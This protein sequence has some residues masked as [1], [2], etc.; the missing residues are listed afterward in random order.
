MTSRDAN[1]VARVRG[2]QERLLGHVMNWATI[3]SHSLDAAGLGRMAD[4]LAE[5][6]APLG[7]VRREPTSPRAWIDDRGHAVEQPLGDVLAIRHVAPRERVRVLLAI[8]YDTVYPSAGKAPPIE[9]VDGGSILRGPGVADAKGGI[10]VMLGALEAAMHFDLGERL[11]WEVLLNA[12]EELGSPGSA[13][14]LMDAA[15][16]HDLG[17]AFEPA[18][19]EAGALASSRK[20]SGNF[21]VVIRGKAAHAGRNAAE[22]RNAVVAAAEVATTLANLN[23][24]NRD[25]SVNVAAI[26]GGEALNVVP[27]VAVVRVNVR[28]ADDDGA[29]WVSR[30]LEATV[31]GVNRRAGYSA[32]LQGS[33]H[34]PP[35]PLDEPTRRLLAHVTACGRDLG[36]AI[37]A[38]P[39]G[40]VCDGNKFAAAGLP[41]I[42]T[43]GVRGGSI[44]SPDE[45]LI[46]E[47]LAERASLVAILLARLADGSLDWPRGPRDGAG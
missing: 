46:V 1:I 19:D 4:A 18:L 23:N 44:H 16:R 2:Q 10:A 3:S 13:G 33:L 28:A 21:H 7:D 22:G 37:T 42:D 39:T 6:F 38:R 11:S 27:D 32:T 35:K 30:Q 17:L 43:L 29:S 26:H 47:S 31:E 41:T 8:H 14:L 20:G 24:E 9:L 25:V 34:C 40:G 15:T 5:T 36:L 45:Y 12:D